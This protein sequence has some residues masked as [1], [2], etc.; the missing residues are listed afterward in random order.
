MEYSVSCANYFKMHEKMAYCNYLRVI[1]DSLRSAHLT[2][3]S[4]LTRSYTLQIDMTVNNLLIPPDDLRGHP[5][6]NNL[7]AWTGLPSNGHIKNRFYVPQKSILT[8]PAQGTAWTHYTFPPPSISI[9]VRS[10]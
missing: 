10:F 2:L 6:Q 3:Y 5:L 7:K 8:A 1:A 4:I 9:P